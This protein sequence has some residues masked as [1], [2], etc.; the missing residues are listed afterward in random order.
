MVR[1]GPRNPDNVSCPGCAKKFV[2]VQGLKRHLGS[3]LY[4]RH[5]KGLLTAAACARRGACQKFLKGRMRVVK[6]RLSMKRPKRVCL[7]RVV[8]LRRPA[9]NI[10]VVSGR[11]G[12]HHIPPGIEDVPSM[13]ANGVCE[14]TISD[15]VAVVRRMPCDVAYVEDETAAQKR[16]LYRFLLFAMYSLHATHCFVHRNL[17]FS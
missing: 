8:V 10:A 6:Q 1:S 12:L 16:A 4:A 3:K 11:G 13:E 17:Q 15:G 9:Q 2:L 14:Q 5:E 7:R